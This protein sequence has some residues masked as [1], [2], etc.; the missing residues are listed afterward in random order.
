M[1]HLFSKYASE[2]SVGY[3]GS[4]KN[5]A[6]TMSIIDAT[7]HSFES[8]KPEHLRPDPDV[9]NHATH[10]SL[11]GQHFVW[12]MITPQTVEAVVNQ[13]HTSL[14]IC[15]RSGIYEKFEDRWRKIHGLKHALVCNSGTT[16]IHVSCLCEYSKS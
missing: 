11:V 7:R 14:S 9:V 8:C 1:L 3:P 5:L 2:E 4:L 12:P 6:D 15:N 13:M 10:A 16:A